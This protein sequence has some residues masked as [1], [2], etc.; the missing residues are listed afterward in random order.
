MAVI[1]NRRKLRREVEPLTVAMSVACMT[2]ASPATQVFDASDETGA[3]YSPDRTLMPTVL[4]PVVSASASDETWDESNSNV[5]LANIRWY[6]N[7]QD[8][9]TL[10][11]WQGLY[12]IYTTSDESRGSLEIRRNVTVAET[13]ELHMEADLLD[14]RA[15]RLV[16]V[17]SD[18]ITLQ[19]SARSEPEY[20][21][22]LED[23][24]VMEYDVMLDDLS[25]D[26]Y[27]RAHSLAHLSDSD[28]QAA[29]DSRN[30]YLRRIP[31][32]LMRGG[33]EILSSTD[34]RYRVYRVNADSTLTELG[35]GWDECA[36][37]GAVGTPARMDMRLV[38]GGCYMVRAMRTA[39]GKETE[40]ARTQF[41][42]KRRSRVYTAQPCGQARLKDGE[43]VRMDM[44]A[45]KSERQPVARPERILEM[46]WMTETAGGKVTQHSDGSIG[47]IDLTRA[48][49]VG[50]SGS[51]DEMDVWLEVRER[52]VHEYLTYNGEPLTAGGEPLIIN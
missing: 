28:R 47:R 49:A 48:G 19:T 16:H 36:S 9:S 25:V 30:S 23:D 21:L 15:G 18:T 46:R 24:P 32:T 34:I 33:R 3:Q 35:G 20:S 22:H 51:A 12:D 43:T 17:S 2:P 40:I 42:L 29:M 4:R 26:D 10:A 7:G 44:A 31:L 1:S 27:N 5:R 50:L 6:A 8:I 11:D 41:Q 45:V 38:E 52:G 14:Q 13:I 37:A 39:N